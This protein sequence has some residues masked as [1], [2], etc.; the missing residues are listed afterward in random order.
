[1]NST[2]PNVDIVIPAHNEA[3]ILEKTVLTL[4]G[5]LTETLGPQEW[6]V[7]IALSG[8]TDDSL[9]L[10]YAMAQ[11]IERIRVVEVPEPGRGRALREAWSTSTAEVVGYV[12]AD[13]ST[14]LRALGPLISPLLSGHSDI[15]IGSRL[16]SN[17][18]V[19]RGVK[20]E[21]ISRGYNLLLRTCL[22]AG[23]SDAQ[24]GFKAIRREVAVELLPWV[25]DEEWFFDTELLVLAEQAGMRIAEVPVDW[26]DDPCSSV[27]IWR[28]AITDIRGVVRLERSLLG[29]TLPIDTLYERLGRRP[30]VAPQQRLLP[31]LVRF[32]LVGGFSTV[33]YSLLF[34]VL[35][36]QMHSQSANFLALLMSAVA[37]TAANR[38][39]TFGVRGRQHLLSHHVQGLLLFAAAWGIT[40]GALAFSH[41]IWTQSDPMRDLL[42]AT[43]ANIVGTFL[44]FTVMRTKIFRTDPRRLD[45][46]ERLETMS[47][48][49]VQSR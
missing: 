8:C 26:I 7:T 11:S 15:A 29:R 44:R 19:V 21:L 1:M 33:L 18:R 10:A 4:C 16:A 6:I 12:D 25:E 3:A 41:N 22:G 40:A 45:P 13:L 24:C 42:V 34:L 14:D 46:G 36:T 48:Y 30:L 47:R 32:A 20:R 27:R 35:G 31:Q 17:A 39:F 49:L 38:W 23:F 37:N 43:G 5:A 28:T 9:A 2:A